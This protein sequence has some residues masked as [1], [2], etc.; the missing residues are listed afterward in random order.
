MPE[1]LQLGQGVPVGSVPDPARQRAQAHKVT[2]LPL[3]LLHG[4]HAKALHRGGQFT[5]R[6]QEQSAAGLTASW[7]GWKRLDHPLE[8][9]KAEACCGSRRFVVARVLKAG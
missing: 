7:E 4:G 8:N 1:A 2:P 3:L 5:W 6:K 9:M